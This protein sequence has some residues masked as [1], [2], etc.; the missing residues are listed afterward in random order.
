MAKDESRDEPAG[1]RSIKVSH[2]VYLKLV[3]R[4]MEML[5][6][7]PTAGRPSFDDVLAKTLEIKR[8]A[9]PVVRRRA[10]GG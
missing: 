5:T 1:V 10:A 2:E 8:P 7:E 9:R 4:Q 6:E 3:E